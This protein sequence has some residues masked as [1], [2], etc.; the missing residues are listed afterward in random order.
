MQEKKKVY[1]AYRVHFNL[2]ELSY[3]RLAEMERKTGLSKSAIVRIAIDLLYKEWKARK[4]RMGVEE[5]LGEREETT[6]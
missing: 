1:T 3:H 4:I 2:D 6:S 5:W